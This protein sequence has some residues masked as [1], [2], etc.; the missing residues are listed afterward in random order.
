MLVAATVTAAVWAADPP[1]PL[2][3]RHGRTGHG[4]GQAQLQRDVDAVHATGVV[5]VLAAVGSPERLLARGGV[6][7]LTTRRPVPPDA[8][9]RIGSATKTFTAGVVLQLAGEGRL[10]L[11]DTVDRWLPGVVHGHGNDGRKV[12]VRQLLQHTSGLYNYLARP[13]VNPRQWEKERLR[14]WRPEQLIALAMRHRPLF[15]A[16]KGWSYSNTNYVLAG[17]IIHRVTGHTW[18]EEVR[19]RIL[20]PLG[21]TRTSAPGT[22][23]HVPEPHARAY[24]RFAPDGPLT[25]VT[26]QNQTLGDAAGAMISTTDDLGRFFRALVGGRLL[27]PAQLAEM[28][29]TVPAEELRMMG[30]PGARYGLGLVYR[31]LSCGGG[32]WSHGGDDS[33]YRTRPGVTADGRRSVVVSATS[34]SPGDLEAE[35]RTGRALDTLVDHALCAG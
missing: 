6:A 3:A 24:Q 27:A 35:Q 8:R 20:V 13:A 21:L 7:D 32:Y 19:R 29:R 26:V 33:G 1:G 5:G 18:Q 16:G 12:T 17:M 34:R 10:S 30:S 11:D 15:A 22:D 14:T 28:Q 23:P 31:P 2:G 25:D 9:F 4:Y